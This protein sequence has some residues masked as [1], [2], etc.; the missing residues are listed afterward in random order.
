[1]L[2]L[3]QTLKFLSFFLASQEE[4]K[5]GISKVMVVDASITYGLDNILYQVTLSVK[6]MSISGC[7]PVILQIRLTMYT[8]QIVSHCKM[9]SSSTKKILDFK[10]KL[11]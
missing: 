10:I 1:M 3:P 5:T 11:V 2:K 9:V 8:R 4:K 7:F 6:G